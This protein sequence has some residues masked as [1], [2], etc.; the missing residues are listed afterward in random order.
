MI[1]NLYG[2]CIVLGVAVAYIFLKKWVFVKNLAYGV[3]FKDWDDSLV[4]VGV[5]GLIGGRLYHVIDF[6]NFYSQNLDLIFQVWRGG[7]G[8]WGGI[9]AGAAGLALYLARKGRLSSKTY[10]SYLNIFALGL[11][12]AQAIGRLGNFF[13]QELFGCATNLQ[14]G[15]YINETLRPVAS[16]SKSY[17]H[18]LFLYELILDIILFVVLL[19]INRA[20]LKK[21]VSPGKKTT[22]PK[23]F[24]ILLDLH[25]PGMPV[26]LTYMTGYALIRIL[27]EPLRIESWRINLLNLSYPSICAD[28][29]GFPVAVLISI[30][31]ILVIYFW[32]TVLR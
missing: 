22:P 31:V 7:L 1:L 17:Y 25:S 3:S 18:P 5:G 10:T 12:L 6:W 30:M 32:R 11:P 26:F 20:D 2:I 23:K 9:L 27:L 21:K 29:V 8:I 14:W 4:W 15:I 13:N 28:F 24:R 19:K 16:K